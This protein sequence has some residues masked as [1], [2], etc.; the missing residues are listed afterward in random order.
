MS[1]QD[2]LRAARM[3]FPD[4]T[5]EIRRVARGDAGALR[6]V[7]PGKRAK[8]AIP[9]ASPKAAARTL[10]RPSA[11][12][13]ITRTILRDSLA[14][15]ERSRVL[16]F[17]TPAGLV[18]DH[19]EGS[20]VDHLSLIFGQ[21]VLIGLMVGSARANQKPVL[22]VFSSEGEELG[23]AKVGLGVL[24]DQ[25][26]AAEGD[27]LRDL[28][29]MRLRSV[30][31]PQVIADSPWRGHP[32]LVMTSLRSDRAQRPLHLPARALREIGATST[33]A[34]VRESRWAIGTATECAADMGS[35]SP[36]AELASAF[37]H[38]YGDLE[39]DFAPWHGDFGPW[40]M[41]R[42][43]SVPLVW[44][45]E[46]F[47]HGMP[48][49]LDALHFLIHREIAS[50]KGETLPARP[51]DRASERALSAYPASNGIRR[52]HAPRFL[53]AA[54]LLT[55][56]TRFISEGLTHDVPRTTSLGL[57]YATLLARCLEA[58]EGTDS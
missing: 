47:C 27:A 56:A 12:D 15:A 35:A 38:R 40:N 28:A 32:V 58:R 25:L 34:I 5:V 26:V 10:D 3:L 49:G 50:T 7:P 37:L 29:T 1:E 6:L 43:S 8:L 23:F 33:P 21:R 31:V 14:I 54:Y 2:L 9:A 39:W 19:S 18:I 57:R 53:L 48:R 45:W 22:N 42:T 16:R 44:D 20:I 4:S 17:A 46:R 13:S 36:L 11:G 30:T 41:A 55:Y 51:L 24:A 52:A